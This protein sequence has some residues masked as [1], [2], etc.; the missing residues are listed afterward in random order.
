MKFFNWI[1]LRLLL[2]IGVIIFL[3]SFTSMRNSERKLLKTEV[4]FED[5]ENIFVTSETVN[6]LL[7]EKNKQLKTIAKEEVD[8][9]KIEKSINS[10]NMIEKSEV[11]VTVNGVL[12]AVV[13]QRTPIARVLLEDETFYFDYQ[14]N[15]M[16]LSDNL[17]ARVPLVSGIGSEVKNNKLIDVFRFIFDDNFLKKNIIGIEVLQNGSLVMHNRLYDFEIDF[18]R[19]IHIKEKFNNYKAFFQKAEGDSLLTK[20]KKINLKF[21]HQ[22]V[23]TK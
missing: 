3:F 18:G 19:P 21:T 2:M 17:S 4:V 8:L 14:G 7:I 20:Y 22:V 6:K 5:D 9:N 13:K 16:P 1:T 23:C 10:H 12:K 11:Y 15:K